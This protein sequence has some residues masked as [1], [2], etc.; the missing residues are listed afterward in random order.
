[1]TPIKKNIARLGKLVSNKNPKVKKAGLPPG[2]LVFTGKKKVVEPQ[3]SLL[4]YDKEQIEEF[5]V[6]DAEQLTEPQAGIVNWY[7]LRGLHDISL[8]ERVGRSFDI[9]PLVLEDVVDI[10]QRPK[11]EAYDAGLF[12]IFRAI[13]FRRERLRIET[14]QVAV[15]IGNDYVI[16]FQEDE[17]DLFDMVRK[18]LHSGRGKIRQRGP[19]YLAYA[20]MDAVVDNYFVV[21]GEV[22]EFI[23]VLEEEIVENPR[24][25]TKSRIHQ[26]KREMLHLRKAV[27]PLREA[28]GQFSRADHPL[29]AEQTVIFLRDLYDHVIQAM[30]MVETYRDSLTGLHDLYISEMSFRMNNVMQVLTIMATIFIPLTFLAGIYGMNFDYMPELH[31]RYS[32]FVLWGIMI[33]ITGGLIYYFRRKGWL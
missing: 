11:F 15:Y 4:R 9:H 14:E 1:M 16:S 7:D 32:Y 18:R 6:V 22:E 20:L 21:L 17:Q 3:L 8:I 13:H 19:D 2:S 5:S 12:L 10:N 30:D 31:W 24:E 33:V 27:T 25:H 29:V 28:V 26:I 23:E